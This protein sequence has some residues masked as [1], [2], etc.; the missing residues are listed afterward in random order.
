MTYTYFWFKWWDTGEWS[1]FYD[2][3][4]GES[5]ASC[6]EHHVCAVVRVTY[7]VA[8][9]AAAVFACSVVVFLDGCCVW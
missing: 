6:A 7:E 3:L 4:V 8:G 1:Q 9:G 2:S 5:V